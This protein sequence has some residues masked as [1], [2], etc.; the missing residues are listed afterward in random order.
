MDDLILLDKQIHEEA[1]KILENKGLKKILNQYGITHVTGS[2]SLDLMTWRD[3]DIY[4]ENDDF[5][6]NDFFQLGKEIANLLNPVKMSFRNERLARTEGLPFGLYW[7]IYLGNERKGAWKIDIWAVDKE[8]C[9]KRLEFCNNLA[10]KISF[11][12][13]IKILE[14]KSQCWADPQYR[15]YYTSNDIYTAVIEENVKDI[16]EFRM[17]LRDKTFR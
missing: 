14:I 8:E 4:L 13:R 5:S 9:Q 15:K 3:L 11:D 2:Y 17:Y 16:E 12:S 10:K 7:G 1:D 6:E